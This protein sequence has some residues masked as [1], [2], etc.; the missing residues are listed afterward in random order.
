MIAFSPHASNATCEE[1]QLSYGLIPTTPEEDKAQAEADKVAED[2]RLSAI[3]DALRR[4][5]SRLAMQWYVQSYS[6]GCET[7][8][9]A[10]A[11][12]SHFDTFEPT[13]AELKLRKA[14]GH[15]IVRIMGP[16]SATDEQRAMIVSEGG[17]A[18]FG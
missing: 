16:S 5:R 6:I 7:A 8:Q 18:T 17:A 14:A 10:A 4:P 15:N 11:S 13:L 3:N 1:W 12:G 9:E 2:R